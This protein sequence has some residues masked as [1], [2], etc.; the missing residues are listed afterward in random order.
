MRVAIFHDYFGAIGGGERVALTLARALGAT[1]YTTDI[2][3]PSIDRLGFQDVRMV[4]LGGLIPRVPLK[5]M[6]ASLRFALARADA[7]AYVLSG[8]WAVYAGRRHHPNLSYC[9]TPVRAF[10]DLKRSVL[11][12]QRSPF[13]RALARGW[14]AVHTAADRIAWTQVDRI[15]AISENVRARVRGYVGRDS[16]IIYPPTD[17]SR[18]RFG[19]LDDFWLSVNR[20]YPEKRLEI[21]FEAFRRL[22]H[23]RLVVIGGFS[24]GDHAEEYVHKLSP[25][26]NVEL[27]GEVDEPELRRLYARCRGLLCTALDEDFG[28]TP[29]EAMASGKIVLAVDEGGF[30]E[31]VVFAEKIASLTT[32]D[33][34]ARADA[35]RRRAMQFDESRFLAA[36]RAS[37]E[38]VSARPGRRAA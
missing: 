20:L 36:M 30:R 22:P 10:Y 29:V 1:V 11:E 8:N 17:V 33:L 3:R 24:R 34:E 23:A 4:S 14:I 6:H 2:H 37:L 21:Q 35:C 31:T 9:Y 5:Q 7:D 13:H 38:E 26:P 16:S 15:V 27:R 18:F 25:P 19:G 28:M 32:A 12:R